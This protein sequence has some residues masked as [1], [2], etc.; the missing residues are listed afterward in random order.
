MVPVVVAVSRGTTTRTVTSL[1][2]NV[3]AAVTV[4]AEA[5]TVE[6]AV[7]EVV[8]EAAEVVAEEVSAE[9]AENKKNGD[10][11]PNWEDW[12]KLE[13]LAAS[14]KSSDSLSPSRSPRLLTILSRRT[15]TP[16]KRRS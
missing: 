11:P 14:K 1:V 4:A 16:L 5:V 13:K 3:L 6:E 12:S 2:K 15:T 10:H 8:A 9:E 7:T